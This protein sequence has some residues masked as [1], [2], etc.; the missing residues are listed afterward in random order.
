[1]AIKD[2]DGEKHEYHSKR[3]GIDDHTLGIELQMLLVSGADTSNAYHQESH[4]LAAKHVAILIYIHKFKPAMNVSKY[5]TP[6]VQDFWG[7]G[8]LKELNYQREVDE[9]TEYLI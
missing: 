2:P 1:M 6:K 9:S 3:Y 5:S 7:Y 4:D 8:I